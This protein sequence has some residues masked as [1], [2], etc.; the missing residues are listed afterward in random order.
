MDI[1]KT[2]P[3]IDEYLNAAKARG[4]IDEAALCVSICA[5]K[6]IIDTSIHP[7]MQEIASRYFK[8]I[9]AMGMPQ[10]LR[11]DNP[12]TT[13]LATAAKLLNADIREFRL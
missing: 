1:S 9:V 12:A 5:F 10:V 2:A 8:M 6:V 3:R 13:P 7:D 11:G 4:E